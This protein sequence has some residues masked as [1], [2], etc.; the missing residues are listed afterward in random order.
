MSCRIQ[1]KGNLGATY[2]GEF[3]KL[4]A[5]RQYTRR[6]HRLHH[7]VALVRRAWL[8]PNRCQGWQWTLC[9]AESERLWLHT[10]HVDDRGGSQYRRMGHGL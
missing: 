10:G 3:P 6:A 8:S 5:Q 1:A 7:L 4:V 2:R 9:G